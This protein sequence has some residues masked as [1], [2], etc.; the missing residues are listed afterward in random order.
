LA[1]V[2]VVVITLVTMVVAVLAEWLGDGLLQT[3]LALL[4]LV[5]LLVHLVTTHDT[6][7]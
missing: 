4:E 1:V 5:A 3:Q 6:E 2:V 7:T